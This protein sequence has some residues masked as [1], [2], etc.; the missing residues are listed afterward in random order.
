[1]VYQILPILMLFY[2]FL[3]NYNDLI[4]VT[5]KLNNLDK[6]N[7]LRNSNEPIFI[8]TGTDC[9]YNHNNLCQKMLKI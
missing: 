1:M 5:N 6:V 3:N 2:L 9:L 7:K 4:N 8:N